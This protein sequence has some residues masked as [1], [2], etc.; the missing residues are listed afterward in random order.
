MKDDPQFDL[1]ED[2]PREAFETVD[3]LIVPVWRS[4]IWI[5]LLACVGLGAGAFMGAIKPNTYDSVGKLL[6]RAG[7]REQ[8]STEST[9]VGGGG[10]NVMGQREA[11][12]NELHLLS[13]PIVFEN[14]AR[15]VG[16]ARIFSAYDPASAGSEK[17]LATGWMHEFQSWWFARTSS[18]DG[19]SHAPDLCG[20]C[21]AKAEEALQRVIEVRPEMGSNVITVIATTNSPELSASLVDAFIAEALV[22]HQAVFSSEN[23]LTFLDEQV[24]A[25]V[26]ETSKADEALSDYRV[27]CGFYDADSQREHLLT[28]LNTL[29]T[30]LATEGARLAALESEEVIV[31]SAL[32]KEAPT[33]KMTVQ[34]ALTPNAEHSRLKQRLLDLGDEILTLEG[35]RDLTAQQIKDRRAILNQQIQASQAELSSQPEF[36]DP[37]VTISE[38]PNTRYV[39]LRDRLDDIRAEEVSLRSSSQK[40]VERLTHVR[41][42]LVSLERCGPNLRLLQ[43]TAT[44]NKARLDKFLAAREHVGVMDLLDSVNMINLRPLQAATLPLT[45]SGPRRGRLVM[46]GGVLG[47]AIGLGLAFLRQSLD[48][49][50][51]TTEDVE[52]VLGT[53][54]LGVVPNVKRKAALARAPVV[55]ALRARA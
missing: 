44:Q 14:V 17:G 11:I 27:S 8:G 31:E 3:R 32:A 19:P 13:N 37:G 54:V 20:A 10:S 39:R 30:A 46:I 50:V 35:S 29:D 26:L 24:Q 33:L 36:L 47:L 5:V 4:R 16:P 15:R 41:G 28:D 43:T 45:K 55:E 52:R 18:A 1:S 2:A 40:H 53:A 6:T 21:V 7:A 22:H 42:Q 49:R 12:V 9:V 48:R 25:A 23:S 38:V 51:R 34:G